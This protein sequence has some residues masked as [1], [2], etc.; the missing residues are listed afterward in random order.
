MTEQPKVV[1]DST[2]NILSEISENENVTQ[3]ELSKKLELSLGSVNLLI[4]RM[5]REG[6][7]KMEHVSQKQVLYMLTPKGI[8]EKAHKT[9]QYLKV[10]YKAIYETKEKIKDVLSGQ[11]GEHDA[12]YILSKDMEMAAIIELAVNEYV[13]KNK[14]TRIFLIDDEREIDIQGYESPVLIYTDKN[15]TVQNGGSGL[16]DMDTVNLMESL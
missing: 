4:N 15:Q 12:V 10:H 6:L 16:L 5:I 3:R 8:S 1:T 2:Y 14:N 9:V 11:A 7:I 13:N